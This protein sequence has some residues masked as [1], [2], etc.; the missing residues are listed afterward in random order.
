MRFLPAKPRDEAGVALPSPV[1]LL[2]VVAV[3]MAA[4]AFVV[5]GDNEPDAAVNVAKEPTSSPSVEAPVTPEPTPVKK[6]PAIKRG[7]VYVEVYNNSNISGLAGRVA[8][9]VDGAGWKVVG[10]DNWRGSIPAST[11]YYP[12]RLARA[13][14]VLGKDLGIKRLKPAV[15]PMRLDRLTVILTPD[16][17]D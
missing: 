10:S 1:V 13:A 17:T 2:S 4:V 8:S 12:E 6:K 14:K 16:Y 11:I 7:E 5:T 9:K 3:A 15:A